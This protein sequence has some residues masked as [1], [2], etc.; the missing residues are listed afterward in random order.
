MTATLDHNAQAYATFCQVYGIHPMFAQVAPAVF[1]TIAKRHDMQPWQAARLRDE[2]GEFIAS[3][4]IRIG[5][6]VLAEQEAKPYATFGQFSRFAIEPVDG[7]AYYHVRD[8]DVP[9]PDG[10]SSVID[11]GFDYDALIEKYS[12]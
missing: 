10:T 6:D 12:G 11:A 2:A 8:A 3:E 5:K 7:M 9:M 4:I 1:E